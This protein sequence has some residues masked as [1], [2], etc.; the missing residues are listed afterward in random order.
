MMK[1]RSIEW[2][3]ITGRMKVVLVGRL[4]ARHYEA[5]GRLVTFGSRDQAAAQRWLDRRV[6][7]D[8]VRFNR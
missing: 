7:Q 8:A 6:K 3:K 2:T 4:G 1:K 5:A